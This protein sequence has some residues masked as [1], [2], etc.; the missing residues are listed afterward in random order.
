MT[1][2]VFFEIYIDSDMIMK[3]NRVY[4][5]HIYTQTSIEV[6]KTLNC[7]VFAHDVQIVLENEKKS[8]LH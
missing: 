2:F 6:K 8:L 1:I 5:L 7:L 4:S 3:E